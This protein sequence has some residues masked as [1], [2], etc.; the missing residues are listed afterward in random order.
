[1]T[2][3]RHKIKIFQLTILLKTKDKQTNLL[4]LCILCFRGSWWNPQPILCFAFFAKEMCSKKYIT[5]IR[6]FQFKFFL[7]H[8]T[9]GPHFRDIFYCF[10][11]MTSYKPDYYLNMDTC[12]NQTLKI[13]RFGQRT[14][15][16]LPQRQNI[17]N[18]D[19]S[20]NF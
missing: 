14:F 1:M 7:L 4:C 17:Q 15:S 10:I 19:I 8:F 5:C 18:C 3:S 11:S 12:Q 20:A 16:Y 2:E 6:S 9:P 13:F